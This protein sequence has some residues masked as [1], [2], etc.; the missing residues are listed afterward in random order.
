MY[1]T[2]K[3]LTLVTSYI[4]PHNS[5]QELHKSKQKLR[6]KKNPNIMARKYSSNIFEFKHLILVSCLAL[7]FRIGYA[8]RSMPNRPQGG[9]GCMEYVTYIEMCVTNF[10]D[11]HGKLSE[12]CCNALEGIHDDCLPKVLPQNPFIIPFFK[13]L[14][15]GGGGSGGG[16]GVIL[17]PPS[18]GGGGGGEGVIPFP[19][20]SSPFPPSVGGGSVIPFPPLSPS[21]WISRDASAPAPAPAKEG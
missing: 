21:P 7:V 12:P 4:E 5:L 15:P 13:T 3:E 8:G 11:N 16:G 6:N 1:F 2:P 17:S 9:Q 18:V 19:P 14:C 10:W 20:L